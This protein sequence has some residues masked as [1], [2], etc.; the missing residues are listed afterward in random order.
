MSPLKYIVVSALTAAGS[1]LVT[2]LIYRWRMRVDLD[3]K[4]ETAEID[5][6]AKKEAGEIAAQNI[7]LQLLREELAKRERELADLREQDR[8]ERGLHA[9]TMTAVKKAIEE[10]ATDIRGQREEGRAHAAR[11]HQRIDV[12]DDRLLVIETKLDVKKR[13]TE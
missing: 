8:R 13:N 9:E 2:F 10:I 5:L 3:A 12:L 4:K 7:P 6:N 1:A 11:V